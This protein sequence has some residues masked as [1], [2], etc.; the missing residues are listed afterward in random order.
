MLTPNVIYIIYYTKFYELKREKFAIQVLPVC[1][2][3]ISVNY[4]NKNSKNNY[5]WRV[6]KDHNGAFYAFQNIHIYQKL[7]CCINSEF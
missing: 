5:H 6:Q 3:F 7:S 1:N 2:V 4:A